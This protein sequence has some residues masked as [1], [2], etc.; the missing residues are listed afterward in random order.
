MLELFPLTVKN[1]PA[2]W[3]YSSEDNDFPT[4]API[5]LSPQEYK[6]RPICQHSVLIFTLAISTIIITTLV[7]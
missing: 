4:A 3:S 1:F 5:P 2:M 6:C 7:E